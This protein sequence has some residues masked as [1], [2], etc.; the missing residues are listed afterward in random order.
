MNWTYIGT[1]AILPLMVALG[2]TM[3]IG[4]IQALRLTGLGEASRPAFIRMLKTMA[5]TFP[6]TFFA[7]TLWDGRHTWRGL[8]GVALGQPTDQR[9]MGQLRTGGTFFLKLDPAKAADW[10]MRAAQGGDAEAQ[11]LLAQ[12]LRNGQGLPRDPEGALRWARAAANQGHPDAMVLCGDLLSPSDPEAANNMYHQALA[13]YLERAR[14]GDPQA[15]LSRGLMC[16]T[17]KGIAPDPVEA[18][19]WMLLARHFGLGSVQDLLI[20]LTERR[21]TQPQR[22]EALQRALAIRKELSQPAQT[23]PA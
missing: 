17:G 11:L 7:L 9:I 12:A 1:A 4:V 13:I 23:L 10:Y 8:L 5:L 2:L 22:A 21:L 20:Q 16:R 15:C 19:A 3:A 18:L 14:K 6:L